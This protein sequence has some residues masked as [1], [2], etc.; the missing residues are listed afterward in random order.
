MKTVN[1]LALSALMIIFC[2]SCN[3]ESKGNI[4]YEKSPKSIAEKTNEISASIADSTVTG[5]DK[6]EQNNYQP[7]ADKKTNPDNALQKTDWDKKIIK[8][9]ELNLEIKNYKIFNDQLHEN[10]KQFGGYVS[11]EEQNESPYKIENVVTIKVPADKF[12]EAVSKLI[13]DQKI[14]EKKISSEDVT[15]EMVDTKARIEA[16]KQIRLRYLD[17]LKQAKNMDEILQV[18]NEINDIQEQLESA[19]SRVEYLNHS[20]AFS[21][22][23]LT[24]YQVLD[25]TAVNEK[26]PSFLYKTSEAFA[27]GLKWVSSLLIGVISLWPL[28]IAGII[29]WVTYKKIKSHKTKTA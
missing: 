13:G 16:K 7:S 8:T 28:W 4:G 20:S 14:I 17:L 25:V 27:E 6:N 3:H 11:Q 18:Q 5:N 19:A 29:A 24:F 12:E 2:L 22:I 15:T 26:E 9:A 23:N 10:V 1:I 21:T